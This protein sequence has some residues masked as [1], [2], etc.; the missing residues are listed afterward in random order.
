VLSNVSA[1]PRSHG[2]VIYLHSQLS[3]MPMYEKFGFERKGDMFLE[4]DIRHF[5]MEKK[6]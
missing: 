1:H 3:A 4:C 5:C 6:Q 2:K